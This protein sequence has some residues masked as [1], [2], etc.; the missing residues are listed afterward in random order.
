[1]RTAE[2][3]IKSY[4]L[5]NWDMKF[6]DIDTI[7]KMI[8]ESRKEVIEECA[9]RVGWFSTAYEDDKIRLGDLCCGNTIIRID[10]QSVLSLINELK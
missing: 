5:P 4:M 6:F 1:M 3:I 2:E 7:I 10:K 8:N 9:E